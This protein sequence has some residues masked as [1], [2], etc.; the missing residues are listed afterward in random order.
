MGQPADLAKY[1]ALGIR[2]VV[3]ASPDRLPEPPVFENARFAVYRT[4]QE[5]RP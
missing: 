4:G 5:L 1:D 3:L 2:Y